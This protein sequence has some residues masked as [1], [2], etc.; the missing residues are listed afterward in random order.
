MRVRRR[1]S[2][3]SAGAASG[4]PVETL[5]PAAPP[6]LRATSP[7]DG[8]EKTLSPAAPPALR[9]TSP[10]DGEEKTLSPAAPP[11]L[12]ATSPCDGEENTLSPAAAPPSGAIF[13]SAA[14]A[15]WALC[16]EARILA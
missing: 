11:A 3:E 16:V 9:A 13:R 6:A 5:S 1:V 7:C 8:E 14:E 10:C 12:R 15:V 2:V 4:E